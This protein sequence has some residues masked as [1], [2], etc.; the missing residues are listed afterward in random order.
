MMQLSIP[1]E[2]KDLSPLALKQKSTI[3]FPD[4]LKLKFLLA[5]PNNNYLARKQKLFLNVVIFDISKA[6]WI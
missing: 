4:K 3:F 1:D 6:K 5:T 2:N